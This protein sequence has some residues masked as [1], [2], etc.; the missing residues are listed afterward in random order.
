MKVIIQRSL[1]SSVSVSNKVIGKIDKGYVI[2]VGFTLGDDKQIV[3]QMINKIINLRV[4]SDENDKLNLSIKD[5]EGSV[6]SISQF[7]LYS[8]LNG[9]RPSFTKALNYND[10]KELYEYFDGNLTLEEAI[11]LIKKRSRNYAKRQYTWFNNQMNVKW[12]DIDNNDFN[13][14]VNEVI[15]YVKNELKP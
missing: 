9:R 15:N 8:K 2:L 13:N 6:L 3:D 4:F 10:A 7:T 1:S 11:S 14:T 5:I 12:F